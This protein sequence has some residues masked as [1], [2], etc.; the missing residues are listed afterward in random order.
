VEGQYGRCND[1]L[2]DLDGLLAG[3]NSRA[4]AG[5]A[6]LDTDRKRPGKSGCGQVAGHLIHAGHRIRPH[7]RLEG[8]VGIQLP[9]QPRQAR[10]REKLV[11]HDNPRNAGIPGDPKLCL[12]GDRDRPGAPVQLPL[13]QCRAHGRLAVRR[14]QRTPFVDPLLH[15]IDVGLGRFQIESQDRCAE[16]LEPQID[17]PVALLCR[18]QR[19]TP[20]LVPHVEFDQMRSYGLGNTHPA[21]PSA[22]KP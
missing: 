3:S 11:R 10:R 18:R 12:V 17:L 21:R 22:P 8:R 19:R 14:Q 20:V 15:H 5:R 4:G 16:L 1:R 7:D 9:G 2:G 13:P 6:D